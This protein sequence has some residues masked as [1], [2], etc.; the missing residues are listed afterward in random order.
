MIKVS[1]KSKNQV[2]IQHA[3][4][5]AEKTGFANWVS[6]DIKNMTGLFVKIPDRKEAIRLALTLAKEGDCVVVSGKGSEEVIMLRGKRIPWNDKKVI[7]DL[8]EREI[9][10][11]IGH[12]EWVNRPNVCKQSI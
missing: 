10:V 6:V 2:R 8:L 11:E 3:L 7:T 12:D 9:E 1:D 5:C 4:S